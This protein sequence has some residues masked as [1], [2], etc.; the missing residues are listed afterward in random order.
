MEVAAALTEDFATLGPAVDLLAHIT[1]TPVPGTV[2]AALWRLVA[3]Y[4]ILPPR[5][6]WLRCARKTVGRITTL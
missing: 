3:R 1:A 6:Y 4:H 5:P 2:V